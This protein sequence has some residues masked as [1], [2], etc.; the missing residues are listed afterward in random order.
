LFVLLSFVDLLAT[1]RMMSVG[2]REGNGLADIVYQAYGPVGM[3]VFKVI[4]VAVVLLVTRVISKSNAR[5]SHGVLWGGIL[6]MT[7][8]TLLHLA[9]IGGMATG[10]FLG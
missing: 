6:V 7:I 8:L 1:L 9:I 5:L 2:I 3:I 10:I 4:L